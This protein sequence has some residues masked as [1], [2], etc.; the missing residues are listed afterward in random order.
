MKVM[1]HYIRA[2]FCFLQ[3]RLFPY[4]RCVDDNSAGHLDQL[5]IIIII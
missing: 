2:D 3:N 4:Q 5:G 1:C